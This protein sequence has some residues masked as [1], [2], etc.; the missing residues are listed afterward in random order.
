M[1]RLLALLALIALTA[2]GG[3]PGPEPAAARAAALGVAHR[4]APSSWTPDEISGVQRKLRALFGASALATSGIAILERK[5]AAALLAARPRPVRS[6]V[7]VQ[8]AGRGCRIG[9]AWDP[10][11][12]SRRRWKRSTVRTTARSTVTSIWSAAAIRR[13]A[14]TTSPRPPERSRAR[15]CDASP[16]PSSPTA[17]AF[18]GPEVNAAWDPDDLQYGYAAGASALSLD[19]GTV[20]I[21]VVPTS[22]GAPARIEVRPPNDDVRILGGITTSYTTS[23][24]IDR[25]PSRNTFTLGGTVAVGAEQ[26]FWR[27]L[28]ELPRYAAAVQ[29]AALVARGIDVVGLG[30]V[31]V[32][33][34]S[35]VVLWQHRSP[36]LREILGQMLFESDNH[37]AEQLLRALGTRAAAT[38]SALSGGTV[39]REV[40]RRLDVPDDGLRIVDGSGLAASDRIEPLSL[41]TLLARA[42]L[43]PNG[44]GPDHGAA[45]RRDRGDRAPPRCHHGA[46]P[47]PRQERAHRGR[48]RAR[49]VRADAPSRPRN[50]RVPGQ[51]PA[52]RR[53]P[54]RTTASTAHW[55]CWRLS[56]VG[57]DGEPG[58]RWQ[59]GP[60]MADRILIIEDDPEVAQ[61]E[62]TILEK[63]GY[64]VRVTTTGT[65][66]LEAEPAFKPA[67][68]LLDV[69]LPDISGLDVCTSLANSSDAFI[70]MVSAHS[71]ENDVLK[72][73]GLGADDYVRKPFSGNE[74]VARVQSFLRR[75]ERSRRSEADGRLQV[76]TTVLVRDFHTLENNSKS[77]SLTALEFR[78]LWYL[79]ENTGKLLTRAQILERV[80]NDVSGVP[81][82]VVDVHVAALRKK[83]NEVQADLQISSVRGIGY[84]LDER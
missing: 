84:R 12:V 19:E 13:C 81:T 48:Q 60:G 77:V 74:L 17:R 6:R 52:R 75:R 72:G 34:L 80:W 46:R 78:L 58:A 10:S 25:A 9:N 68:I 76:G 67:V 5:R 65:A 83:L 39:E 38:G 54:R 22:P 53:R 51:R 27:P 18:S 20:E 82:R 45:A 3:G 50:V 29:R 33:P 26:S 36:P 16:A 15:A 49:G 14:R 28:I 40:L 73:L 2:C 47:G 31:G 57:P 55:T 41:A 11:T 79:A 37:D 30:R 59:K 42:A 8:S 24:T 63:A 21:H 71:T 32:A 44:A 7:D 4:T 35:G 70:L 64:E 23:L 69:E 43:G 1:N 62:R 61:F 66:G 56:D